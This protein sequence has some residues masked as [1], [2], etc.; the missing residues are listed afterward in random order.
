MR[1]PS[2]PIPGARSRIAIEIGEHVRPGLV[3]G[4][5]R[6][7]QI[8]DR[9]LLRVDERRRVYWFYPAWL[10]EA[11]DPVAIPIEHGEQ[12]HELPEAVRQALEGERLEIRSLFL[13]APISVARVEEMLREN[14][15]GPLP[16]PGAI[17]TRAAFVVSP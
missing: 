15:S 12:R 2:I 3:A 17:E 13:D 11:D 4:D 9:R 10:S 16:I 5:E 14:P 1:N 7:F 8:V 6:D